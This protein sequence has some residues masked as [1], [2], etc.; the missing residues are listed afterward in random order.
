V[1]DPAPL[2]EVP[3]ATSV[4]ERRQEIIT[5]YEGYKAGFPEVCE[6]RRAAMPTTM[7]QSLA[8]CTLTRVVGSSAAGGG[9][10]ILCRSVQHGDRGLLSWSELISMQCPNV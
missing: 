3:T 10:D 9:V 6:R 8:T 7:V 1:A 2:G 4:D 5:M